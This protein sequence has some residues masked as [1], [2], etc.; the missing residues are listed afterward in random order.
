MK[1]APEIKKGTQ[2]F[3]AS[4]SIQ[5]FRESLGNDSFIEIIQS[6][7]PLVN[8]CNVS[9]EEAKKI[10]ASLSDKSMF[11]KAEA[12]DY[13]MFFSKASEY[14]IHMYWDGY[15][16]RRFCNFIIDKWLLK[17]HIYRK[18]MLIADERQQKLYDMLENVTKT[19]QLGKKPTIKHRHIPI[20]A[21]HAYF[22]KKE[23][24]NMY[25]ICKTEEYSLFADNVL[26][27]IEKLVSEKE[28]K[29][30]KGAIK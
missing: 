10:V 24:E 8:T 27:I 29:K 17:K 9:V 21:I 13:F 23:Y 2:Y 6:A 15:E 28:F 4:H 12:F 26:S 3:V 30:I 5:E 1:I 25:P 7:Q 14:Y 18:Q 20:W 16:G 19:W 22:N 11:F